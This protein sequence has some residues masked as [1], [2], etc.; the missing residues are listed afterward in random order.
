[1][2]AAIE[3]QWLDGMHPKLTHVLRE[4]N[5]EAD[6]MANEGID[7]KRKLPPAFIEILKRD[8]PSI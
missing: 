6:A 7:K 5:I 8:D 4:D 1:M 2:P 3:R